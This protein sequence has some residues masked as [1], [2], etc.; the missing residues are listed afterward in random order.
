MAGEPG[1]RGLEPTEGA[2]HEQEPLPCTWPGKTLEE[3][4]QGCVKNKGG[5]Y[6]A[7][8]MLER[9]FL[10][11]VAGMCAHVCACLCVCEGSQY[12]HLAPVMTE[13]D[14]P[15]DSVGPARD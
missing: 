8:H 9:A 10:K 11:D 12:E 4:H 15:H 14:T 3:Q 1:W 5:F 13:A 2:G 7:T 6:G